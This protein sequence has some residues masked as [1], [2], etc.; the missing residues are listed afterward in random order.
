[1]GP[2]EFRRWVFDTLLKVVSA[3]WERQTGKAIFGI[4]IICVALLAVWWR[5]YLY[6]GIAVPPQLPADANTAEDDWHP[7]SAEEVERIVNKRL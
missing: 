1:M 7:P 4:A 2:R 5:W 3:L 6:R